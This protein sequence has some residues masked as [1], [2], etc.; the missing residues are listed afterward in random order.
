MKVTFA[1]YDQNLA[2]TRLRATIP[3]RELQKLGIERGN[4][5]LVYGKHFL[6][7]A[8][9]MKFPKRVFDVCDDHFGNQHGD[10]YRRHIANAHAVTCNSEVM[11]QVIQQQTGRN[12][13]VIKE[14]Y[15]GQEATCRIG[16][17]LLWY[18]H[19]SNLNDFRRIRPELQYPC[20]VLTNHP[21]FDAW[22]PDRFCHEISRDCVVIIPTGKSQAKSENRFVEAVRRGR[23]VCAEPL[24]SYEGFPIPTGDIPGHLEQVFGNPDEALQRLRDTQAAIRVPYSPKTIAQDWLKVLQWL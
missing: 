15:E 7:D 9:A 4:D 14:P 23:Y 11:R 13:T 17:R 2:S 19:Q 18:G 16:K 12:S 5:V 24:P 20:V 6:P 1:E 3:Q 8:V 10:Y 22:T 21:E